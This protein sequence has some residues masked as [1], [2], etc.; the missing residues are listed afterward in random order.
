MS[1]GPPT[2]GHPHAYLNDPVKS[3]VYPSNATSTSSIPHYDP[4]A[5]PR[6]PSGSVAA[7]PSSSSSGPKPPGFTQP[8]YHTGDTNIYIQLFDLKI[9]PFSQLTKLYLGSLSVRVSRTLWT[10]YEVLCL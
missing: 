2:T 3:S 6:R 1:M 5:P 4:Y 9:R 8:L 10:L 7:V